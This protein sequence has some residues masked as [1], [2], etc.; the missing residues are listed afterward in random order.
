[1]DATGI[2]Q[3]IDK[4]NAHTASA[5]E[6]A[7]GFAASRQHYEVLPEH[8]LLKL[9][10][11][12]HEGDVAKILPFLKLT[13]ILCGTKRSALLINKTQPIRANLCFPV[14]YMNY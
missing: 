2:K 6:A 3:L 12:H 7:A 10:E 9:M 13:K 8:L 5:L 4:L 11:D 14:V 1:M